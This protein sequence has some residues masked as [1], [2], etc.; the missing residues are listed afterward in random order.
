[1]G[2]CQGFYCGALVAGALAEHSDLTVGELWER[3]S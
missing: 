2:R 3:R 1:M